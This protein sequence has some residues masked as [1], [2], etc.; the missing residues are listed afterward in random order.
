LEVLVVLILISLAASLVATNVGK[1]SI[2]KRTV[3]FVKKVQSMCI[4]ARHRAMIQGVP[5]SFVIST[6]ER[7]CWVVPKNVIGIPRAIIIEGENVKTDD[8]G[9]Y[10]IKFY[11]DGSSSGGTLFFK[12]DGTLLFRLKIDVLTGIIELINVQT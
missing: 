7:S 6:S 8:G 11:P 2:Q 3:L 5:H 10:L 12:K 4:T 1:S 9:L